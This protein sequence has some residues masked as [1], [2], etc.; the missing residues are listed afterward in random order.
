L[1]H[2]V[3]TP[4]VNAVYEILFEERD[5]VKVTYELMTRDMKPEKE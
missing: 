5:P 1:K 2:K 3:A 4:I